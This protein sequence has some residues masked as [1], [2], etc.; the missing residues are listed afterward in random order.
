[1]PRSSAKPGE[2]NAGGSAAGSAAREGMPRNATVNMTATEAQNAFGRVLDAVAKDSTVFI[3]KHNVTRAVVISA[4]RYEA[5]TRAQSPT[6]D[7]LTVE[8]DELLARMQTAEAKAGIRSAFDASPDELGR[9]AVDAAVQA[10][11]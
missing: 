6:L 9:A 7:A 4:D 10:A 8:F 3:Q 5:L 11:R 2:R 1:M